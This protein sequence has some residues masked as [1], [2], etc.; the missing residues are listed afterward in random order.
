MTFSYFG[1]APKLLQYVKLWENTSPSPTLRLT[2]EFQY[3]S[4]ALTKVI[5][6]G[7][8]VEQYSY[9]ANNYLSSITD[10]EATPKTVATF[11]FSSAG[12]LFREHT[13]QGDVGYGYADPACTGGATGVYFNRFDGKTCTADGPGYYCGGKDTGGVGWKFQAR[14]CV[15]F[16]TGSGDDLV[17]QVTAS[18][19][20]CADVTDY[21]WDTTALR[22][23]GEKDADGIWTSRIIN[24]NGLAT[25][26]LEN[27]T[28]SDASTE[29]AGARATWF[30]YGNAKQSRMSCG[31]SIPRNVSRNQGGALPE[32]AERRS[33]GGIALLRR[34]VE[35][36]VRRELPRGLPDWLHGVELRRI[37]REAEQRDAARVLG[38]PLLPFLVEVVAG[39]VVDDQENLATAVLRDEVLEEAQE[40][41]TVE[42]LGELEGKARVGEAHGSVD[43]GSLSLAEGVDA[44]LV[45]DARPGSVEGSVEPETGLVLEENH[46]TASRRFFLIAGNRSSS[47]TR[48][49]SRSA[50]ASR[51]RGRW[52]ENPSLCSRRGM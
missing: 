7:V 11:T 28:D 43:V 2:V 24:A 38:E 32:P 34:P 14:R 3:T 33:Q 18:C 25:K 15:S 44:W 9:D 46:P 8:T 39:A 5:I 50:R 16:T 36:V 37:R 45:P 1:T 30:F 26:V 49:F 12:K 42:D 10:G 29:P 21:D 41:L 47:Q 52:T 51:F 31:S 48:C 27:D 35:A 13:P 23:K 19:T 22:V 40:R 4:N 20:T 6:G 17:D